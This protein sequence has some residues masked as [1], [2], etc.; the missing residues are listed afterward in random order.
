MQKRHLYSTNLNKDKTKKAQLY[1]EKTG[2]KYD[3]RLKLQVYEDL[4]RTNNNI[5]I[6][7]HPN[8]NPIHNK[9]KI[10]PLSGISNSKTILCNENG[11]YAIYES[12]RFGFNNPNYEWDVNEIEYLLVGDSFTHGSCVNRPNDIASVLRNLSNKSVLNLGYS[13]NGPLVEYATL[14]EYLRPNVKKVLWIYYGNDLND[15]QDEKSNNFLINYFND[16]GFSQ[17]LKAEQNNIN[18]LINTIILKEQNNMKM[19]N[20][21]KNNKIEYNKLI[22][23]IKISSLRKLMFST[24]KPSD[25]K[26]V[27]K[28]AKDLTIEN[29]SELYLVYLPEFDHYK[30][31]FNLN[32]YVFVKKVANELKIPFIDIYSQVFEKEANPLIYFPFSLDGHYNVEGYSEVAKSI[33]QY[34]KNFT[35]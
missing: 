27:L 34:T 2:K 18:N 6:A 8:I 24:I 10:F 26:K 15:L 22:S 3:T 30:K 13:S 11:Y 16:L 25:F 28:L 19:I 23:F 29:N 12:D 9:Y 33:Y 31:K 5:A 17:N 35:Y 4:K 1:R 14:R 21:I 32:D 20:E 7:S